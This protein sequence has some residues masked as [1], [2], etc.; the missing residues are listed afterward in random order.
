MAKQF[1]GVNSLVPGENDCHSK[2]MNSKCIFDMNSENTTTE[3][4]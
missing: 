3:K 4:A 1:Q 2:Y